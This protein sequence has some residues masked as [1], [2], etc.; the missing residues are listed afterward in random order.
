MGSAE[1]AQR[2]R[3]GAWYTP[4]DLVD[5]LVSG[6]LERWRLPEGRP[7][8]VVD[9]A[10]G[11]GRFLLAA[12]RALEAVA[13]DIEVTG[14]DIDPDAAA[15]AGAALTAGAPPSRTVTVR[16]GDALGHDWQRAH[17]DLVIGNPP[18][19]SQLATSTSR[20]RVGVWGGG[21]YADAAVDF[22]AMALELTRRHGARLALVLPQ[23]VLSSRDAAPVRAEID[24]RARRT[25]S[26]WSPGHHFDAAVLVCALVFETT[27]S[28]R[29]LTPLLASD[30]DENRGSSWT[31]IV[32]AGLGIPGVPPLD[33]SGSLGDRATLRANFRDEY[34][35]LVPGVVDGGDGPPLVT[36]GL[37]DPGRLLWGARSARFARRE[38]A[39]PRVTIDRLSPAMQ[40]WAHRKLVPKVL[41]ASQT[42]VL[43]A[44][45]DPEGTLLPGVPVTTVTPLPL[46]TD[47]A[48]RAVWEIAAV[49]TSPVAT[50]WAWH[51]HA[52]SGL[53][54]S[55][56]RV[57][58]RTLAELPWPEGS[59]DDAVDALWSGDVT[60]CGR[61]VDAAY[62]VDDDELFDWWCRSL[63]RHDVAPA[64]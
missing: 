57:G 20:R 61:L 19:L 3:T 58:P 46:V 1:A 16:C 10:C 12:A 63:P 42:R 2:K 29:D 9:P 7:V 11:D 48:T 31:G 43:E 54:A 52:G 4:P 22:L 60:R 17:Y 64:R 5:R 13:A 21:V 39:E 32:A 24:R 62:G 36:C 28:H 23:S 25:W 6:A 35:G 38:L 47:D 33:A 15:S 18:F 53:S 30:R 59:L 50:V 45:A 37:I 34:Y 44:V 41:V 8:R 40:A 14:W 51:Q 27:D 56:M 55:A 26:W 49:L